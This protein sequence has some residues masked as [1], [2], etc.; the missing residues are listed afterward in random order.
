MC[1]EVYSTGMHM[2]SRAVRTQ[3]FKDFTF[4]LMEVQI[5]LISRY[6]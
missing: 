5:G 4:A 2:K 3:L 1:P 6:S